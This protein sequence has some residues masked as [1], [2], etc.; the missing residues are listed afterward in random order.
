MISRD[1]NN[2]KEQEQE[3]Q[4][5]NKRQYDFKEQ[6]NTKKE[7]RKE[8]PFCSPCCIRRYNF[9]VNKQKKQTSSK[10]IKQKNIQNIPPVNIANAKP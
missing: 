4:R 9:A 1:T 8:A 3:P 2:S 5:N 7:R 10:F 6:G